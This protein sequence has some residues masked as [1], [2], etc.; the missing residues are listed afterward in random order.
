MALL[1]DWPDASTNYSTQGWERLISLAKTIQTNTPP[2]VEVCLSQ[3][4]NA[5]ANHP[6]FQHP[7]VAQLHNDG[8]LLLLLRVV[9]DLPEHSHSP[10]D[11]LKFFG[12]WVTH[13]NENN[14]DGTMNLCWP[15]TWPNNRP[16]LVSGYEGLQGARYDAASEYRYF[17]AK[18]QYRDL[19]SF[20]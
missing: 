18:Y 12:G 5:F 4:Q 13:G 10:R 19:S 8:K 9:F 2:A 17:R 3:Y 14:T 6:N 16:T 20:K 7:S 1:D 11:Q 15:L